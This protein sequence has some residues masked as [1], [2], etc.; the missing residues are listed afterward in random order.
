MHY[1]VPTMYSKFAFPAEGSSSGSAS[2]TKRQWVNGLGWC[3][4]CWSLCIWG[5]TLEWASVRIQVV[6][7]YVLCSWNPQNTCNCFQVLWGVVYNT[8]HHCR[9]CVNVL[10]KSNYLVFTNRKFSMQ[11]LQE[12]AL[13]LC[14]VP[15]RRLEGTQTHVQVCWSRTC[16]V[17]W[18]NP[19]CH[20]L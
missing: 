4:W 11:T 9:S 13:L 16:K 15:G 8:L 5:C 19:E 3:V 7:R 18:L 2:G 20:W 17:S 6:Q 1:G 12:D 14:D 10:V